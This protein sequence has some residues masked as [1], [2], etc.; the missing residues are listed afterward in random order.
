MNNTRVLLKQRAEST[1]GE[2]DFEL[3]D[4][5][6]DSPAAGELL[7]WA[8]SSPETSLP[9]VGAVADQ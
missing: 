5:A 2:Q 4:T 1:P 3:A 7:I 8:K 9:W 6:R